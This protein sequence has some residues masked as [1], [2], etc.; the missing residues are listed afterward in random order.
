[1][2]PRGD[3]RQRNGAIRPRVYASTVV[4]PSECE[5]PLDGHSPT[6]SDKVRPTV[7][8]LAV[9]R[10]GM[11]PRYL[12][13]FATGSLPLSHKAT[14]RQATFARDDKRLC[15]ATVPHACKSSPGFLPI[16]PLPQRLDR[17]SLH[18]KS[19]RVWAL[20][21]GK[22][23]RD[24]FVR[25]TLS[26]AWPSRGLGAQQTTTGTPHRFDLWSLRRPATRSSPPLGFP[27]I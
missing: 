12:K 19:N 26:H 16:P 15:V 9:L 20:A 21:G 11:T 7:R 6:S 22:A 4:I 3:K 1:M 27:A 23:D 25:Q 17:R 14:A 24:R 8:S 5:G 2:Q 18:G 10:L 13:G